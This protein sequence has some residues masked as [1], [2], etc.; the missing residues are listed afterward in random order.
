MLDT[1]RLA[2]NKREKADA[3]R[4]E[5]RREKIAKFAGNAIGWV[6]FVAAVVAVI[7]LAT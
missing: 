4:A 5:A 7:A 3:L 6:C 1:R 2:E